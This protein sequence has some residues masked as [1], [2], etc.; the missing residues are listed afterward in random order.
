[1]KTMGRPCIDMTGET[2]GHLVVLGRAGS[3]GKSSTWK[4]HC[5]RCGGMK[6]MTRRSLIH[7]SVVSCGCVSRDLVKVVNIRHGK[8]KTRE[9]A[10]WASMIHRCTNPA[11]P[12]Y[13]RY[14]GRGIGV[15]DRWLNSFEAFLGDMGPRPTD[16]MP[17]GRTK[18]TLERIDNDKGYSPDNCVWATYSV[19]ANNRRQRKCSQR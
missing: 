18:F 6:I 4:C 12:R 9:F 7:P 3:A 19:Q 15:C 17:S 11:N 10:T 1:V 13:S 8:T 5:R 14:G 2:K 16:T